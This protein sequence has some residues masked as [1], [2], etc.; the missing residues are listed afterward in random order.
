MPKYVVELQTKNQRT[1][2]KV[3]KAENGSEAL[4]RAVG[5]GDWP[6]PAVLVLTI[7]DPTSQEIVAALTEIIGMESVPGWP[8]EP[9]NAKP[10]EPIWGAP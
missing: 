5:K 7:G 10:A 6:Q 8:I 1:G 3:V 2:R 4:R 9:G